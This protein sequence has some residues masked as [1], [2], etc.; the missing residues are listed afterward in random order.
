MEELKSQDINC[1]EIKEIVQVDQDL[2]KFKSQDTMVFH[3]NIQ[4]LVLLQA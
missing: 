1:I 3:L 2:L 4:L